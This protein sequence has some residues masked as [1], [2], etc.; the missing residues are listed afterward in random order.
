[1]DLLPVQ[2]N[3]WHAMEAMARS[4]FGRSGFGFSATPDHHPLR[5]LDSKNVTTQE[6]LHN[7]PTLLDALRDESAARF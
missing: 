6:L 5:I 1:M 7:A 2:T 4:H 3:R